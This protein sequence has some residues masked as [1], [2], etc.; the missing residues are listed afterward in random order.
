[1]PFIVEPAPSQPQPPVRNALP[2]PSSKAAQ[3]AALTS[4]AVPPL[5]L[6]PYLCLALVALGDW[7]FYQGLPT[8]RWGAIIGVFA[9]ALLACVALANPQLLR[10]T[11]GRALLVLN[12]GLCVALIDQ[13]S[14][15]AG[16][17]YTAGLASFILAGEQTLFA[18]PLRWLSNLIVG[19][20]KALVQLTD[21]AAYMARG[22][23]NAV[24]L[25]GIAGVVSRWAL[26]VVF[27]LIFI[28]LFAGA[29]PL[30]DGWLK[31]IDWHGLW[32]QVPRFDRLIFWLFVGTVVWMALRA[33]LNRLGLGHLF[34]DA[35]AALTVP[36]DVADDANGL[37]AAVFSTGAVIRSMVVFNLLFA[38]QNGMDL[39]Y[40]WGGRAL[41]A[42]QTYAASAHASAYPLIVTALIAAA[43]VLIAF[44]P[45]SP[46]AEH[47]LARPL[48]Y[49]WIVQNI[50]L[51]ASAVWRTRAY[52]AEYSLTH[53]RIAALIWMGLVAVG[54]ALVIARFALNRRN[55]WLLNANVAALIGVLYVSSF[56]NFGGIIAEYNVANCREV[57]GRG[58][59][60]DLN[61]LYRIGAPSLLALQK[62]EAQF[63]N[64]RPTPQSVW[65]HGNKI[66]IGVSVAAI[67]VM[68]D[69]QMRA[70]HWRS[71]TWLAHRIN[72]QMGAQ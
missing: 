43:F 12:A 55:S 11:V 17:L 15:L 52:V 41:P 23:L 36:K 6:V 50:V 24:G 49:L 9:A 29:N 60:I 7:F 72:R 4:G 48:M 30:L 28:A 57:T 3:A 19:G 33:P 47:R 39:V 67:R 68:L 45:S 16:V 13:P 65:V 71:W 44:R 8:D 42:G 66:H 37:I 62:Y 25:G 56:V 2:E 61:Y 10:G 31:A 54:L 35:Q 34:A 5:R 59:S 58:S 32:A 22:G 21:D 46:T 69:D 1:M 14:A 51:V 40:L 70:D 26:P 38:A 64:L 63:P 53:L 18:G 27:A 20:C